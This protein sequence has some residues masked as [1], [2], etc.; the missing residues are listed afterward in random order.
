MSAARRHEPFPLLDPLRAFAAVSILLVHTSLFSGAIAHAGYGRLLAHLDIGVPFFF[1]LS[2]FLLYR[3]FVVARLEN[4]ERTPF[5]EYA[6]RRFVR[7]AP[8][9][10]AVLTIAAVIPG[11]AGAFTGNWWVYYGL[12]QSLPVYDPTGSCAADPYRCGVPVAGASASRF[13][14]THS[15]R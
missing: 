1:L 9:Y 11:F 14:S 3:P 12:L 6:K 2:A 4:R 15:C 5:R 13:S 7:I 10:W 8:A